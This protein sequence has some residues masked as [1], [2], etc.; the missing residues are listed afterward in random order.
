[1][2]SKFTRMEDF[3]GPVYSCVTHKYM[4]VYIIYIDQRK[5]SPTRKLD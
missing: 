5:P 1:M 4:Y 3:Q 2:S